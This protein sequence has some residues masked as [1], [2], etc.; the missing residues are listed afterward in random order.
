MIIIVDTLEVWAWIGTASIFIGSCRSKSHLKCEKAAKYAFISSHWTDSNGANAHLHQ[1][2]S[3]VIKIEIIALN[4]IKQK[5]ASRVQLDT[6]RWKQISRLQKLTW[7]MKIYCIDLQCIPWDSK[8]VRPAI[9]LRTYSLNHG[10]C[11][12]A[13]GSNII[14]IWAPNK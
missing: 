7:K 12:S 2:H 9:R 6:M 14:Q 5:F 8:Q 4:E 1:V 13:S 11:C 3:F 10:L